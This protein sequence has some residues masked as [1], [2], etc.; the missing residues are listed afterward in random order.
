MEK[1]KAKRKKIP[2][3]VSDIDDV[4][5]D[6]LGFLCDLY[7]SKHGT[8]LS[9]ADITDWNWDTLKIRDVG[10]KRIDGED[11]KKFFEEYESSF[12]SSIPVMDESKRAIEY[13]KFLGYKVILITA[14]K[15]E[16]RKAT[17]VCLWRNR[18]PYDDLIFDWD[19]QKVI[20]KLQRNHD[21]MFFADDKATTCETVNDN[22]K[23]QDTYLVNKGHNKEHEESDG[24][25][26]IDNLLEVIRTLKKVNK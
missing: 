14:R 23:V 20:K 13:F 17:E 1:K 26:R 6:F 16:H 11:L 3:I 19:K 7:N 15:E 22:C 18:V 5:V 8:S 21:I 12:Y 10:S 25:T 24:I 9:K 4:I 2:C